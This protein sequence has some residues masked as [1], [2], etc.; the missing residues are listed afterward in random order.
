MVIRLFREQ[1][2]NKHSLSITCPAF[3]QDSASY[4]DSV[5][6]DSGW[7]TLRNSNRMKL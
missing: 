7:S 4:A 1:V 5:K 2:F 6:E 3:A